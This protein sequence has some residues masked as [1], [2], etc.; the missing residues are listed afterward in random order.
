MEKYK[1]II[2]E[3]KYL[4]IMLILFLAHIFFRFYDLENRTVFGWDQVDNAW[5]AKDI[6]IDHKMPLV[7]MVAKQNTGF[8]IGPFYYYFVAFFYWLFKMDPIAS[9]L[10][11]GI[12]SIFTFFVLFYIVK[13]IF[14]TEVALVAVFLHTFSLHVIN[15]DRLQWPINFLTPVSLIIFYALYKVLQGNVKYAILLAVALGFSFHL[16]FTSIFF[17]PMVLLSS[18]FVPRTKESFKYILISLPLFLAWFIPNF[19]SELIRHGASSQ[20]MLQYISTYFHGFHLKRFFQ[21]A[22]DALIEM[23]TFIMLKILQAIKFL[24]YPIF[25]WVYLQKRKTRERIIM[26]Y[27]IGLWLLVPWV[28]LSL[29]SGEITD[30]YFSLTRPIVILIIAYL[31][32]SAFKINNIIP[33]I[34]LPV[35]FIYYAFFNVSEF[36]VPKYRPLAYYR[37]EVLSRIARGEKIEF[38]QGIPQSYIYYYYTKLK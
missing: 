29:Y 17:L 36:L 28:M 26:C 15:Y 14:S 35:F 13:K 37:K 9:G 30:Y 22:N 5:A 32:V 33:K 34:A 18:P 25:C 21:L 27:L 16:N 23:E 6:I 20:K 4:I 2:L 19:I 24:L 1:K 3:K 10:T 31:I 11:A 7:G 38:Q 8:Y 12:T